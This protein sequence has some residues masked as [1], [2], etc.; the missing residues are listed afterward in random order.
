MPNNRKKH[1][2]GILAVV[3]IVKCTCVHIK[4]CEVYVRVHIKYCEVYVC[5]HKERVLWF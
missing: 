5:T 3:S 4:Y 1:V 2:A